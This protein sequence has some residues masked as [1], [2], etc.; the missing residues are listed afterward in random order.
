MTVI[1]SGVDL[2]LHMGV[3]WCFWRIVYE[4]KKRSGCL[5]RRMPCHTWPANP[6]YNLSGCFWD[7]GC[8]TIG[9]AAVDDADR[10]VA[11]KFRYFMN[12]YQDCGFPPDWFNNPYGLRMSDE[13][14][15]KHWSLIGDFSGGDI[16][17]IWELGRFGFAYPLIRTFRKTGERRYVDAFWQ[18]AENWFDNN[19]PNCGPHWRCGQEAAVR[20]MAW[21]FAW[22]AAPNAQ[23][24]KRR[25]LLIRLMEATGER[26]EGN[27]EYALLQ[28]NNH[29][30]SEAA[31]LWAAGLL[32]GV[33]CW[34][35]RGKALLEKQVAVLIYDDG[36]FS[37]H[38]AN[39]QR[40]MLDICLWCI[41]LGRS[42]GES[43]NEEFIGRIRN[44]G[45]LLESLIDGETGRV[46]NWGSN[47]GALVLPL[48]DCDYLD[49]RPVVQAV[50]VVTCGQ[51]VFQA[52]PWDE[53]WMWLGGRLS[54]N[55]PVTLSRRDWFPESGLAVLRRGASKLVFRCPQEFRHRP[56]QCDV[57]HVDVW[58]D[59][60]NA[61]R[62]AGSFSYN[63]E[64]PWQKYFRS[65]SAHNT[66]QFDDH[67]QMQKIGRFLY[68]K[69]VRCEVSHAEVGEWVSAKYADEY[70]CRHKRM[71]EEIEGGWRITDE[72][73]GFSEKAILRWRL[74]PEWN[75]ETLDNGCRCDAFELIVTGDG[76]CNRGLREGWESLYYQDRRAIPVYE[77]EISPGRRKLVSC[78]ITQMTTK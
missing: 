54:S 11:G 57:L 52:G 28:K 32:L 31:G 26:I 22:F 55:E 48:T 7:I 20:L 37:Q 23:T 8:I 47:D 38:S 33:D 17:G 72:L 3:R 42:N 71:V 13:E 24:E 4:L 5:A 60:I 29:G 58:V 41:Q 18:L 59:G 61:L 6:K 45:I 35:R 9:N 44:T 66:V 56:S 78:L 75:W 15:G 39:Y 76:I 21:V 25:S 49:Y 74:A 77:I 67:D 40:L 73:A 53:E 69:W 65:V 51:R 64:E 16:K 2:M 70:G 50:R 34:R 46:P 30:I 36:G 1:S 19:P 43:F 68:G 10:I 14:V 62:D 63:C 12:E 27:I